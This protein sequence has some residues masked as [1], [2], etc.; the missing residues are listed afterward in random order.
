MQRPR[1]L[2]GKESERPRRQAGV[3]MCEVRL[4][5]AAGKQPE[6]RAGSQEGD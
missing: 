1:A 5:S 3:V 4:L 6:D 2:K